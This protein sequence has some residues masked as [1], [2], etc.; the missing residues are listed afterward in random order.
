MKY[1]DE[2]IYENQLPVEERE[3]PHTNQWKGMFF[4]LQKHYT[5]R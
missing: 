5:I 1:L 4:L 2:Y 3:N